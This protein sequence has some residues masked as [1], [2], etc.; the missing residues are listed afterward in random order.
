MIGSVARSEQRAVE[1]GS[2]TIVY[3]LSFELCQRLSISVHP[4]LRVT[5][6]APMGRTAEEVDE[7]VRARAPWILRQRRRFE[8]YHPLP[9]PRRY[10]SG[11]TH[12]Y[13]GRQY[14]L[15]LAEGEDDVRLLGGYFH[16]NTPNPSDPDRVRALLEGWYRT[17]AGVVFP[18]RL[19]RCL[20]SATVLQEGAS[21][22]QI[23]KMS[24]RWG[25]CTE[26]GTITLNLDLIKA[27]SPCIDYVIMHELCHLKVLHHGAEFYRL[28]TRYMPDW[29]RRRERL[30][31]LGV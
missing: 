29:Q 30:N 10:I 8:Q 9:V 17:R 12:L 26:A 23:R 21:A 11:E 14:R 4:D 19:E 13:L 20:A 1:Y 22:L 16:L 28:L 31:A 18:Q 3:L 5:A 24:R 2:E 6:S 25:S 15:K 7:R 27:P